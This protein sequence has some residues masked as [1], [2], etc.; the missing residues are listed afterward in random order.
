MFAKLFKTKHGQLLLLK[1]EDDSDG[2]YHYGLKTMFDAPSPIA[3]ATAIVTRTGLFG[4]TDAGE[5]ERD[6]VFTN[7]E[8]KDADEMAER[9]FS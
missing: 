2:E 4:D 3:G 8:Q 1:F 6:R 7:F 9:G 5:E